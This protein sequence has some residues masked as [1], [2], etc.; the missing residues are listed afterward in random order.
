MS[1][2][3]SLSRLSSEL[4]ASCMAIIRQ[5]ASKS[6]SN[7][8]DTGKLATIMANGKDFRVNVALDVRVLSV[9][10]ERAGIAQYI[11]QLIKAYRQDPEP[12]AHLKPVSFEDQLSETEGC[13]VA[14][15]PRRWGVPWQT[16]IL[17]WH[18]RKG[19]DVFHGPAFSVPP[20]CPVARVVTIHDLAFY[21]MPKTV[22]D[23][24]ARYLS[25]VVPKS[26]EVAAAIIVPSQQIKEDLLDYLPRTSPE[27]IRVVP[28]GADRLASAATDAGAP[29]AEPY[30][31][32][33]GTIEP[34]KN[35]AL[36]IQGYRLAV[37]RYSIPHRLVLVGAGGWKNQ[38]VVNLARSL[39]DRI[40]VPG[41][42]DDRELA[43]FYRHAALY[44]SASHYEGYGIPVMEALYFGV[45]TIA[46]D[47]GGIRDVKHSAV[48][49][50]RTD[51]PDV[52]AAY[53]YQQIAN[54]LEVF[55]AAL[56]TWQKSWTEHQAI[57][58]AVAR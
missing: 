19:Y 31:L 58:Q 13:S 39:G 11:Q 24:T 48:L 21:R 30:I 8:A 36:V 46:T 4:F 27:K 1:F 22:M 47:T 45:P 18:L 33:V 17:P 56:P 9:Q 32:H 34:R 49:L 52:L 41:Y 10:K 16:L 12:A 40:I 3:V 26:V 53:I 20:V 44:V 43:R 14:V 42:V 37:E 25:R 38:E 6:F 15:V 54:P 57:Y 5:R 35:I 55:P 51:G 50:Q 7:R 28:L 23:D 2:Y 29:F